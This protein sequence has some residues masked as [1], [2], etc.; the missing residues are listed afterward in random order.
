LFDEVTRNLPSL[1]QNFAAL[2]EQTK[3]SGAKLI[4]MQY[5]GF[6]TDIMAMYAPQAKDITVV[7][8]EH[9]FDA[10]PERYFFEARYPYAYSH[11]TKDGAALVARQARS[12]IES[13]LNGEGR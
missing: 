2:Y 4:L 9:L 6:S 5:P 10:D 3:R 11:F 12:A 13:Y 1:S 8:N 7:D